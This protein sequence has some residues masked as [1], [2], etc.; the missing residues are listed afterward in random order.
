M[1]EAVFNYDEISDTLYVSFAPGETGTGIEINENL[2]LRVNKAERR[3][4]G[5]SIFNYSLLAQP[6]ETGR[7]SLPLTG[8]SE[9][10]AETRAIVFDIL[11]HPP[12]S[13]ILTLSSYT[14]RLSESIPLVSFRDAISPVMV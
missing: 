6:T 10:S 12:V 11:S 1:T 14:P 5:L 2:L 4:I 13:D 7:R 9:V 8:L 3:A